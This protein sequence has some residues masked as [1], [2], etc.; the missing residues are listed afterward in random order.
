MAEC[1]PVRDLLQMVASDGGQNPV[2]A[3]FGRAVK[4]RR[5]E[6]GLSQFALS[7]RTG[8]HTTYIS[9]VETGK[10][11]PSLV[12]VDALALGLDLPVSRLFSEYGADHQ[13]PATKSD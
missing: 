12:K 3:R 2:T 7:T 8:I 6:L 11:N 4:A 9:E 1:Q 5:T 10:K 13:S